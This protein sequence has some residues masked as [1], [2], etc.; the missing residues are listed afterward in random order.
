MIKK[1]FIFFFI[2]FFFNITFAEENTMILK[3]KDGEVIIEL[4]EDIAPKHAERIKKLAS[5]KKIGLQH[6]CQI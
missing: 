6:I 2:L 5:E 1:I 3:L 4:F